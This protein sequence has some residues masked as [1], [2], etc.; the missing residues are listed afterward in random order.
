MIGADD[1]FG[2]FVE[3][4]GEGG[5]D[6]PFGCIDDAV[7]QAQEH[8]RPGQAA[9]ACAE[10]FPEL[11]VD[12]DLRHA[13][14]DA[15]DVLQLRDRL[16]GEHDARLRGRG[17]Q[18]ADALLGAQLLGQLLRKARFRGTSAGARRRGR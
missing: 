1:V 14:L 8:L 4:G 7:L 3:L 11:H 13:H 6:R 17:R 16:V 12:L 18:D 15:R 2:R 10:R 9:R 5:R